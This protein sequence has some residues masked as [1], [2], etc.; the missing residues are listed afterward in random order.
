MKG[1]EGK[2]QAI[3]YI[4]DHLQRYVELQQVGEHLWWDLKSPAMWDN[5]I[6]VQGLDDVWV[7]AVQLS[8]SALDNMKPP[9]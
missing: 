7:G 6:K 3:A 8:S 2:E 1:V 5:L 9:S 4:L